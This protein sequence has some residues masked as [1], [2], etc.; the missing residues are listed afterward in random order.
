MPILQTS[1]AHLIRTLV[2]LIFSIIILIMIIVIII[3]VVIIIIITIIR[4]LRIKAFPRENING[5]RKHSASKM[6]EGERLLQI[7]LIRSQNASQPWRR[8]CHYSFQFMCT[9]LCVFMGGV[10]SPKTSEFNT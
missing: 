10:F 5:P 9:I 1:R 7:D 4:L 3:V 8:S 2:I 6:G